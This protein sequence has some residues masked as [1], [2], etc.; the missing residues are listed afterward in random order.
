MSDSKLKGIYRD[1]LLDAGGAVVFD[2]EWRPNLIV[3]NCRVLL[4]GF[5]SNEATARGV[6]SL[7]V[8]EGK[9]EWDTQPPPAPPAASNRLEDNNP[10][11]IPVDD[12]TLQYLDDSDLIVPGPT[13]RIEITATLGLNQ[14]TSGIF[15]LREF[16]L[17]G[18]FNGQPFMIDYVRHPV[19]QKSGSFTLERRVRLIF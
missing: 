11:V 19:I 15:N 2:S 7:Q 10:F 1:R 17:F 16:G 3:T 4:A 14:P 6:Q 12:L 8:G 13:S 5:M 9:P 18:S